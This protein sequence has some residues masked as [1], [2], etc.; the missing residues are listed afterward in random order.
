MSMINMHLPRNKAGFTLIELLVVLFMI[1]LVM[2]SIY[3]LYR[4]SQRAAT[5]ET[6][7]VEVQQNLRIAMDSIV[8]DIHHAGFLTAQEY[9]RSIA[10]AGLVLNPA[11]TNGST[12]Q[13]INTALVAN[14][15]NYPNLP[16]T[17]NVMQ[18]AVLLPAP[19]AAGATSQHA[20]FLTVN[21][22]SQVT[23]FG[24][25]NQ[26]FTWNAGASLTFT[27]STQEATDLFDVPTGGGRGSFVRI[28]DPVTHRQATSRAPEPGNLVVGDGTIYEVTAKNRAIRQLTLTYIATGTSVDPTG[29]TY[30]ADFAGTPYKMDCVI[31][32]IDNPI[33]NGEQYPARLNYCLG[34]SA[35]CPPA[36]ANAVACPP[37][38]GNPVTDPALCLIRTYI[39]NAQVVATGITGLQ[40]TYIF[41]NGTEV[42]ANPPLADFTQVRA[43]RVTITGQTAEAA[44]LGGT[45]QEKRRSMSSIVKLENRYITN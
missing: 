37:R 8:R 39:N 30:S 6:D 16:L 43:I 40:F 42:P 24:R 38:T 32:K 44:I 21:A 23:A 17:N 27:L 10:K 3:S 14:A 11:A 4:T 35:T 25:L 22:A 45:A 19:V 33:T 34:P 41:D 29:F 36:G 28:V 9:N 13:A 18:P 7:V 20:D 5:V 15:A 1:G 12:L 2:G 26:S 31:F